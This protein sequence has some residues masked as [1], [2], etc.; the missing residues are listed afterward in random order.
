MEHPKRAHPRGRVKPNLALLG[1]K[2]FVSPSDKSKEKET[3]VNEASSWQENCQ[4]NEQNI[5]L[6]ISCNTDHTENADPKSDH[7][8][9]NGRENNSQ[10]SSS[11]LNESDLQSTSNTQ[12]GAE[13][14]P[15]EE[16]IQQQVSSG[17]VSQAHA[18]SIEI[19]ASSG[20]LHP[21]KKLSDCCECGLL[22]DVSAETNESAV[23]ENVTTVQAKRAH[24]RGRVAPKI[25]GKVSTL[26]SISKAGETSKVRA[27]P[28]G[29]AVP[30]LSK[31]AHKESQNIQS[32]SDRNV[33]EGQELPPAIGGETDASENAEGSERE[34][35][36]TATEEETISSTR[37]DEAV[38]PAQQ[39]E[40]S[41]R[42]RETVRAAAPP[43]S[44]SAVRNSAT[45]SEEQ[46][47]QLDA[48]ASAASAQLK[49]MSSSALQPQESAEKRSALPA[50]TQPDENQ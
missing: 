50:D 46:A 2:G 4:E 49:E 29:K 22:A 15:R 37:E 6:P 14:L 17:S 33:S 12:V 39:A 40:S 44:P 21:M 20:K 36:T 16:H 26:A 32:S 31:S 28:R 7:N 30:K 13:A 23:A 19:A 35:A 18:D 1:K 8:P 27:H 43:V 34:A 10:H 11:E 47:Y 41:S 25:G 24:P 9:A 48:L 5:S 42:E 3:A 38:E 45:A